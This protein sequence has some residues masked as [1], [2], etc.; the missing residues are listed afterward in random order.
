MMI[1]GMSGSICSLFFLSFYVLMMMDEGWLMIDLCVDRA[2]G[3]WD[4]LAAVCNHR[5]IA[6]GV[7]EYRLIC[8]DL[9]K[10]RVNEY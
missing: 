7:S 8:E 10:S 9:D 6:R 4:S 1:A 2:D 5:S 3:S